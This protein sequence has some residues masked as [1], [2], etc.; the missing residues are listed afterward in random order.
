MQIDKN[1]YIYKF[2]S[3]D[4]GVKWHPKIHQGRQ[5]KKQKRLPKKHNITIAIKQAHKLL[6]SDVTAKVGKLAGVSGYP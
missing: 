6:T 1:I 4:Q 3:P 5:K 2:L